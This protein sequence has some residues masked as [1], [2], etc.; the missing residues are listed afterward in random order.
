MSPGTQAILGSLVSSLFGLAGG[1]LLLV[2][3][4]A[5]KR[6]SHFFVS[7]A[8]GAMLGSAFFDILQE[9]INAYPNRTTALFAWLLGGFLLF[10][11]IEKLLLWH[12]HS[13][14]ERAHAEQRVVN[15]LIIIGDAVHNFI[16]GSIIAAA[17]LVNPA[18]G[19]ATAAAILFHE[20]PQEV[21]D[22]SLL[23]HGGMSRRAVAGWNFLGALVS[24]LGTVLTLFLADRI[25]GLQLPLL[26]LAAGN[27]I[28]IAAADL[29]PQ[30]HRHK[31]LSLAFVELGLLVVGILVIL[32]VGALVPQG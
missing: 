23:I 9:S 30:I 8:A 24:P 10:F 3:Y 1:M 5:V 13:H 16:D 27:F 7:F 19:V 2:N 15:P 21:G 17:F 26:G 4:T 18:V 20:L 22:F 11:L 28:Y 29:V 14:D 12:H 31:R 6:A 25:T 32:A